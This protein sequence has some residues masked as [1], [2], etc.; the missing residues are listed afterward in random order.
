MM[1]REV[2]TMFFEQMTEA[3]RTAAKDRVAAVIEKE[4]PGC[5]FL[6]VLFTP[7]LTTCVSNTPREKLPALLRETADSMEQPCPQQRQ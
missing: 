3:E 2:M 6:A 1:N 7:I 4:C 5:Y